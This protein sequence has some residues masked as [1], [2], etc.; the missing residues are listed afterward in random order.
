MTLHRAL[1]FGMGKGRGQEALARSLTPE[2]P[3]LEKEA[4]MM[5]VSG[6]LPDSAH[7]RN[8]NACRTGGRL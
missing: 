7:A 5:S 4:P 2:T 6:Y 1:I 3:T 8:E